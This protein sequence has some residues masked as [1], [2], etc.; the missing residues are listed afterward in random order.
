MR[1]YEIHDLGPAGY[2][3]DLF[4]GNSIIVTLPFRSKDDAIEFGDE[5]VA[6]E[7]PRE[8][9]M[10]RHPANSRPHSTRTTDPITKGTP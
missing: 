2:T 9:A 4:K 3:L 8:A 7:T 6:R 5:Y 1:H 10:A